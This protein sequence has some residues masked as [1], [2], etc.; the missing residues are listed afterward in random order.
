M[1]FGAFIL[2]GF[3]V[4]GFTCWVL[5]LGLYLLGFVLGVLLLGFCC[6]HFA[7]FWV[8]CVWLVWVLFGVFWGVGGGGCFV[9]NS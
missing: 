9:F 2:L 6:C 5:L 3:V 1:L 4:G 7:L 8:L